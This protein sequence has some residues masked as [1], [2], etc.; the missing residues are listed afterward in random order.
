[1]GVTTSSNSAATYVPIATQTASGSVATL[2][3]SSI[4]NTYTDLVLVSSASSGTTGTILAQLNGDTS[5]TYSYTRLTGNGTSALSARGTSQTSLWLGSINSGNL[6]TTIVN[7]LNYAN[8]T[9]YKTCLVRNNDTSVATY[10]VVN[11][12]QSTSAISSITLF[13]NNS[14]NFTSSSTFTL[15]GILAA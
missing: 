3:F 15:Y 6:N 14:T 2:T 9:T 8:T 5:G 10:G 12:W 11:L 4:P 13:T 1:M 7:F